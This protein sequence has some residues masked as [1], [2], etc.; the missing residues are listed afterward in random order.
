MPGVASMIIYVFVLF[1]SGVSLMDNMSQLWHIRTSTGTMFV[2]NNNTTLRKNKIRHDVLCHGFVSKF[3]NGNHDSKK[4]ELDLFE[5]NVLII[6]LILALFLKIKSITKWD[7]YPVMNVFV[8]SWTSRMRLHR[9]RHT[10]QQS[11][12]DHW[13]LLSLQSQWG[14]PQAAAP[15]RG[16]RRRPVS[17]P[18]TSF[19]HGESQTRCCPSEWHFGSRLA[20]AQRQENPG[21]KDIKS[22]S[23]S[24]SEPCCCPASCHVSGFSYRFSFIPNTQRGKNQ[25]AFYIKR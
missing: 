2:R 8:F 12:H 16:P 17:L 7:R 14:H 25:H 15:G 3:K 5:K 10:Q 24:S 11:S 9:M 21:Q 4:L 6:T 19:P 13:I 18:G 1:V 22:K 20:V 23:Q